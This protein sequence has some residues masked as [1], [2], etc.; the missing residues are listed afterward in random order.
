MQL[1]HRQLL[2]VAAVALTLRSVLSVCIVAFTKLGVQYDASAMAPQVSCEGHALQPP[3]SSLPGL[4][5]LAVWDTLFF[6]RIAQCGYE[7]EQFHAF[8]P[9]IPR[10]LAW[11]SGHLSATQADSSSIVATGQLVAAGLVLNL[12]SSVVSAVLL[13]RLSLQVLR[14]ET[15]AALATLLFCLNPATVF[16]SGVYTEPVFAMLS[17]LALN[18]LSTHFLVAATVFGLSTAARSN[19]IVSACFIAHDGIRKGLRTSGKG[20]PLIMLHTLV[21]AALVIGPL[22]AFQLFGYAQFCRGASPAPPWCAASL[23]YLYGYVQSHYW[24]VGFLRYFQLQQVP[25]FLL[26][27]P[28]LVLTW[29]GCVRFVRDHGLLTALRAVFLPGHQSGKADVADPIPLDAAIYM[30]HWAFLAAYATFFMHVQVSTRLLSSCPA[31]Y[32]WA[33]SLCVRGHSRA[34]WTYFLSYAA[35]GLVLFPQFYP[36]T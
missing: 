1:A 31:L 22:G 18:L 33:A 2:A 13:F 16:Y 10:L 30:A 27:M 17:L 7:Y 8:F 4:Q 11:L 34:V 9:L 12:S 25:N 6:A 29:T 35:L 26:A 23:P 36:W 3:R 5:R 24:G 14:D 28:V 20:K 32:W 19:G 15:R 21:G